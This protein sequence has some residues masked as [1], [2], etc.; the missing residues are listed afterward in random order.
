MRRFIC[1]ALVATSALANPLQAGHT[2]Q[3]TPAVVN[4]TQNTYRFLEDPWSGQCRSTLLCVSGR[5][6]YQTGKC[7]GMPPPDADIRRCHY[8][9]KCHPPYGHRFTGTCCSPAELSAELESRSG[10]LPKQDCRPWPHCTTGY[11]DHNSGECCPNPLRSR[12][13]TSAQ[14]LESDREL[15]ARFNTTGGECKASSKCCTRGHNDETKSCC[16]P[17]ESA[18]KVTDSSVD[19]TSTDNTTDHSPNKSTDNNII[20]RRYNCQGDRSC[21]RG[22]RDVDSD[23]CC[24]RIDRSISRRQLLEG[25]ICR[26]TKL[27]ASGWIDDH[28]S[29]CCSPPHGAPPPKP[30]GSDPGGPRRDCVINAKC[31]SGLADSVTGQCCSTGHDLLVARE[32]VV[33]GSAP[34]ELAHQELSTTEKSDDSF[35]HSTLRRE[36]RADKARRSEDGS[37]WCVD[38]PRCPQAGFNKENNICCHNEASAG[39]V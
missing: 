29:A 34:A 19:K 17:P 32:P 35:A 4:S 11:M 12:S 1:Y 26:E 7:C 18:L 28:S 39:S 9:P 2:G 31:A 6:D 13:D 14:V 15:V 30:S 22:Y 23:I 36:L 21:Y 33:E 16:I 10:K 38:D 5:V 3:A 24:G 25:Y 20:E 8:Q 27:C 37:P